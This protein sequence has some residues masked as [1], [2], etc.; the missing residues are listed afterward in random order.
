[1]LKT[2][3]VLQSRINN[4]IIIKLYNKTYLKINI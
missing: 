3:D 4:L 1:M 2:I